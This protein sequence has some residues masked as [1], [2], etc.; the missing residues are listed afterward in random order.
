MLA[1]ISL[2]L[3]IEAN[4]TAE[5]ILLGIHRTVSYT[6]VLGGIAL[7]LSAALGWTAAATKNEILAFGVSLILLPPLSHTN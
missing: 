4:Y 7:F 3:G 1:I 6:C 2:Y 5:L